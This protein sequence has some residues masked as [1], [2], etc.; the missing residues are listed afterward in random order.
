MFVKPQLSYL[1]RAGQP[2]TGLADADVQTKLPATE[3]HHQNRVV[4]KEWFSRDPDST[5]HVV[6]DPDPILKPG[7]LKYIWYPNWQIFGVQNFTAASLK[8][9]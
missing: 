8:H 6:P 1:S 7:Q 5:F 4:N 2:V 9:F 3:T